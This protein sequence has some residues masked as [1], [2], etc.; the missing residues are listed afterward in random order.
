[1]ATSGTASFNP[2]FALMAEDAFL[3]AGR[4]MKSG[5]DLTMAARCF[6]LLTQELAN[7]GLNF[8]TI[9]ERSEPLLSGTTD[10]NLD[11][12]TVDILEA[13]I[14]QNDGTSSQVDYPM[15]RISVSSYANVSN[16]LMETRPSQFAV[17]RS[18]SPSISVYPTPDSN[19]YTMIYWIIRRI[20]D[21]GKAANNVDLPA[22]FYPV[23]TA[24]LGYYIALRSPDL[25]QNAADCRMEF[26]RQFEH[27]SGEDRERASTFLVPGC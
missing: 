12:D 3:I 25:R 22:R 11:A 24:G 21:V 20:E 5:H 10:Y 7:R 6:D 8:W 4:P 17:K 23:I 1:V 16:K 2:E 9:E 13:V 27:A 18:L 15:Q 26:E 19:D 14:R